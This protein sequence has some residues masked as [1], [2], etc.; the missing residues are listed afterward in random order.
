MAG[1]LTSNILFPANIS[2]LPHDPGGK[3]L[4]MGHRASFMVLEAQNL[5]DN[6]PK[7]TKLFEEAKRLRMEEK[8]GWLAVKTPEFPAG[9]LEGA[10]KASLAIANYH[11]ELQ[12]LDMG[13]KWLLQALEETPTD[14]QSL[15]EIIAFNM[16]VVKIH[17]EMLSAMSGSS[18]PL[19]GRSSPA[20][21]D[22]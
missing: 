14:K 15:L 12:E 18:T 13:K 6:D 1:K 11:L 21:N 3:L 19:S 7:K 16:Q 17:E 2:A 5:K 8:R 10:A 22:C 20:A 9:D 4:A